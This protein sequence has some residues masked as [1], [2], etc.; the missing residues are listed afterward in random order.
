MTSIVGV[1]SRDGVVI[2]T[3]S[4][5]TLTYGQANLIEQP[6]EKIQIIGDRFI[7]A[8]TGQIGL[9]QRFTDIVQKALEAR[10]LEN[11]SSLDIARVLAQ[12]TRQDFYDTKVEHNQFG[13]LIAF[14]TGE[15][16]NLC[17]FSLYDFQP[18]MKTDKL[19]FTSMGSGQ[20]ITD[21]FL[22]LIREVFWTDGMPSITEAV[23]AVTW[24]LDHVV[25]INPGGINGPV[26][27]SVLEKKMNKL[28]A[29]M[30]SDEE[31]FEHRE[32]IKECKNAL[33]EL[34]HKH[35]PENDLTPVV[36]QPSKI[37]K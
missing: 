3:D 30:L 16:S 29:R 32:N 9:G 19:W 14:P 28:R 2:G 22:A 7:V 36:P 24:A 21:P 35:Q 25:A 34:R 13:A 1:L 4:S 33:R 27:I 20:V 37:D 10:E 18:E 5:A 6:Y 26:K 17:E 31:L 23:F 15:K 11:K 12:K 8:G